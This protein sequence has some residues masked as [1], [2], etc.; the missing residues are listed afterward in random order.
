[1]LFFSLPLLL[2]YLFSSIVS[3]LIAWYCWGC[4][5]VVGAREYAFVA[6]SQSLWTVGY[7]FELT[8]PRLGGKIFWD[9]TQ[10]VA[11]AGWIAAFLTFTLRYTERRLP[12]PHISVPLLVAPL[13]ALIVL[14]YT[15]QLHGLIRANARLVRGQP[16]DALLYD[17]TGPVW[18][19]AI[20]MYG[21]YLG[22]VLMLL[23]NPARTNPLYRLQIGLLVAGSLVPI[24]GS[25]LSI[26]LLA[27]FPARD[28]SPFTFAISSLLVAWA[29]F[30]FRLFDLVPIARDVVVESL[31][32]AVFVLDPHGRLIDLNPAARLLVDGSGL[33][34][35]RLG[36]DSLPHSWRQRLTH[37]HTGEPYAVQ[38]LELPTHSGI[39]QVEL[40]FQPVFNR[41]GLH[42][43]CVAVVRD[44]TERKTVEA[45]LETYRVQLEALVDARTVDLRET[46][47]LLQQEIGRRQ[48][49]EAQIIN[50]QKL[51]ALG[52]MAGGIAHDF[53]NVLSVV[54]GA[55]DMLI[56]QRAPDDP[57]M[58]DLVAIHQATTQAATLTRQLLTFSRGQSLQLCPVDLAAV[59]AESVNILHRLA[60]PQVQLRLDLHTGATAVLADVGQL[61]Q[62]L[63][64]L[65]VNA[66]DAMPDGGQLT[67]SVCRAVAAIP[68][69]PAGVA[70]E[71]W[72]RLTV[73]D[74]GV[75]MDELTRHR[76]FEPFFTTKEP[77][78]GTGLGLPVVYGI[79]TQLGGTIQVASAPG[80]GSTFTIDLPP[81]ERSPLWSTPGHESQHEVSSL[82]HK[83]E[84]DVNETTA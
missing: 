81:I 6:L 44:I 13:A 55:A 53:N 68:D 27:D 39:R 58:P 66:S 65:V 64:N 76:L 20:Y 35:G 45:E 30:R 62:V 40:R 63:V 82:S 5:E 71:E 2:A 48:Q 31:A 7:I 19:L 4:Y 23:F 10:F 50:G 75:G 43:G 69:H 54:R 51:E 21:A 26:S 29:L 46:N 36:V 28:I 57:D 8:S 59:I 32:D 74:S 3:A 11:A 16:Y 14:A 67:I 70:V 79:V 41:R 17:V 9:N 1:M 84:N 24:L 37:I 73:A 72:V 22:C 78:Y 12:R 42:R 77:G 38:E 61:Q 49:L 52:R 47:M 80:R 56:Q 15:N 25:M 33:D 83:D 18:A 60:R 34:A